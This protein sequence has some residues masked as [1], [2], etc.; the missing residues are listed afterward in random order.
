LAAPL[1][2][3]GR[4]TLEAWVEG[5]GDLVARLCDVHSDG[6]SFNVTDG[7]LRVQVAGRVE[8]DL[9]STAYRFAAGHRLRLQVCASDFPRYDLN[10]GTLRIYHAPERPSALR[11]PVAP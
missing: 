8:V 1:L 4:V 6:R 10:P 3:F 7:I 2:V 11:L 9:W 5:A